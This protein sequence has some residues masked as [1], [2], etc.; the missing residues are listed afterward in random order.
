MAPAPG[1]GSPVIEHGD[2][3]ER[4]SGRERHKNC[5]AV[6]VLTFCCINFYFFSHLKVVWAWVMSS[7]TNKI[8]RI[9]LISV[10]YIYIYYYFK[11]IKK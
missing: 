8:R 11:N 2:G 10:P 1:R 6:V 5:L 4:S 7:L 3:G 9:L